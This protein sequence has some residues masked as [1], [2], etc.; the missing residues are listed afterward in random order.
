MKNEKLLDERAIVQRC[1]VVTRFLDHQINLL[2]LRLDQL[3]P[4]KVVV[5]A[6][7]EGDIDGVLPRK[8]ADR[9]SRRL[10]T[11]RARQRNQ[12]DRLG[13]WLARSQP[14]EAIFGV[15]QLA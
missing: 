15:G 11:A 7:S 13:G 3:L 1:P 8:E 10:R 12:V 4:Q 9:R 2:L 14:D 5:W 6:E